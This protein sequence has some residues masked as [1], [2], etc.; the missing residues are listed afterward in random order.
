MTWIAWV[1]VGLLAAAVALLIYLLSGFAK[2][3]RNWFGW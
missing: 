1:L 3:M 2:S